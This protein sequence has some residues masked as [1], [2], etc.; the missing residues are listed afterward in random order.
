MFI[1]TEI[2]MT[3]ICLVTYFLDYMYAVFTD[4]SFYRTARNPITPEEWEEMARNLAQLKGGRPKR[5][6]MLRSSH[7]DRV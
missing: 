6:G 5:M 1:N 2:I 7:F 4:G 3:N